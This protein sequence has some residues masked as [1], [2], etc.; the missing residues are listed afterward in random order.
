MR[1]GESTDNALFTSQPAR[2]S[3]VAAAATSAAAHRLRAARL[4][5]S[6]LIISRSRG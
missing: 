2:T 4:Y 1:L 6:I 3:P 5:E